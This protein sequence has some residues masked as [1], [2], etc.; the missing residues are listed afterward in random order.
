MQESVCLG[1]WCVGPLDGIVMKWAGD[2]DWEADTV[3]IQATL[4]I[5]T[6]IMGV[7]YGAMNLACER[8]PYTW[9]LLSLCLATL[10]VS[11]PSISYGYPQVLT[12][13]NF[14]FLFTVPA[15]SLV[16]SC[17]FNYLLLFLTL[18]YT[19]VI[20]ASL[21]TQRFIWICV[22]MEGVTFIVLNWTGTPLQC[23]DTPASNRNAL[24]MEATAD[25]VYGA[26]V[27]WLL[28]NAYS[29]TATS[30]EETSPQRA[31]SM[32]YSSPGWDFS[33]ANRRSDAVSVMSNSSAMYETAGGVQHASKTTMTG[34]SL[35][36]SESSDSNYDPPYSPVVP[37]LI[38]FSVVI[39]TPKITTIATP[40]LQPPMLNITSPT[41]ADKNDDL[42][43]ALVQ[44]EEVEDKYKDRNER[45]FK[46]E[47]EP[48]T[49]LMRKRSRRSQC[50]KSTGNASNVSWGDNWENATYESE[51][52]TEDQTKLLWSLLDQEGTGELSL[53]DTEAMV[54]ICGLQFTGEGNID[55]FLLCCTETM[56][57][58]FEDFWWV[59]TDFKEQGF[60]SEW[61]C[62]VHLMAI[63]LVVE[64]PDMQIKASK[65]W[66]NVN[67]NR[68]SAMTEEYFTTF[69][70]SLCLPC[71]VRH[72][73][74][75]R[76]EFEYPKD[77]GFEM[78]DI[79]SMFCLPHKRL[80]KEKEIPLVLQQAKA[81]LHSRQERVVHYTNDTQ[82]ENDNA[83]N[84][85]SNLEKKLPAV[86]LYCLLTFFMSLPSAI[87][88]VQFGV[89]EKTL[90]MCSDLIFIWWVYKRS[91]LPLDDNGLL[92]TDKRTI[93]K[94]YITSKEFFVDCVICMPLDIIGFVDNENQHFYRLNKCFVLYY[95][96][97]LFWAVG[98][99]FS[100]T[101]AR[102]GHTFYWLLIQAHILGC[103]FKLV[104]RQVGD[105]HIKVSLTVD[106]Y[107]TLPVFLQYCQGY[108]WALKTMSGL[109][110]GSP[111][112]PSD[113]QQA[114]A[115]VTV[116]LGVATYAL[117]L[118]TISNALQIPTQ[119]VKFRERLNEVKSFLEYTK[120]PWDYKS[121]CISYYKHVYATTG[122]YKM[123]VNL[124]DDL[125]G[126]L[127]TLVKVNMCSQVIS[128]VPIFSDAAKN[129]EFVFALSLKLESDV[130]S[131]GQLVTKKGLHGS[132]MYFVTFGEFGI[133]AETGE[134]VHTLR[135]GNFFG[136]IALLHDVKRTATIRA[137]TFC[138]VLTLEKSD[139]EEVTDIFPEA[140][141]SI[142]EAAKER[143]MKI[144]EEEEE[145]K[146]AARERSKERRDSTT[147][148]TKRISCCSSS[149]GKSA[150]KISSDAQMEN[151]LEKRKETDE[152][153][154][155]SSVCTTSSLLSSAKSM[156]SGSSMSLSI[157]SSRSKASFRGPA[158]RGAV[159]SFRV[160]QAQRGASGGCEPPPYIQPPPPPPLP[161]VSLDAAVT[162]TV[163]EDSVS[164]SQ[165][166]LSTS[167]DAD[168]PC[169]LT[170]P[171]GVPRS[172]GLL[173]VSHS[174]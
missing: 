33:S 130:V 147:K 22:A 16:R 15:F 91:L 11:A 111:V 12:I 161:E 30:D 64:D 162:N 129:D 72:L 87:F 128:K 106:S 67:P 174:W 94:Y 52:G 70:D 69:L 92:V 90:L 19:H 83:A 76:R 132:N 54:E 47:D 27:I 89:L 134:V 38:P 164:E 9:S 133:I 78:T 171:T 4:G 61:F 1:S 82:R 88:E 7:V 8:S 127:D 166:Q 31:A 131:P 152:K 151:W 80:S 18:P 119:E 6:A 139:F 99:Q 112:P 37:V 118:T 41:S 123:N 115:L 165:S 98:S 93:L 75:V 150:N 126:E 160:K 65:I 62:I 44:E 5:H 124:L 23:S 107:S 40:P 2:V 146:R 50:N 113:E 45:E 51:L 3:V 96:N 163:S 79:I 173:S 116:F 28:S 29:T 53:D 24:K 153:D 114:L 157:R 21:P 43:G 32:A 142:K 138:N 159:K 42:W 46:P 144:I 35:H 137:L 172:Q 25:F 110:R 48:P 135:A 68:N 81:V 140:L 154:D 14:F 74:D 36:G 26:V 102:M 104:A 10:A 56:M 13:L 66:D 55:D 86:L 168:G 141:G 117:L 95:I 84:E 73:D 97:Y 49:S 85:R 20:K 71:S 167:I 17:T 125:P 136:E 39:E 103:A 145:K 109:S 158:V 59:M 77:S 58:S 60:V 122:S 100:P 169:T 105:D 143:I 63:A 170:L 156:K 155:T 121:V 148:N 120:L 149:L 34:P 57:V 101:M 108:D